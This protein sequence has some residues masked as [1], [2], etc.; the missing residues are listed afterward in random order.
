[1]SS[2]S[3]AV[4]RLCLQA[5]RSLCLGG[6]GGAQW[7]RASVSVLTR[8]P[9]KFAAAAP[10]AAAATNVRGFAAAGAAAAAALDGSGTRA[11]GAL[12]GAATHRGGAT[13]TA[14]GRG[15]QQ[16]YTS[17]GS[18]S[19]GAALRWGR[20]GAGAGAGSQRS[21]TTSSPRLAKKKVKTPKHLQ[22]ANPK[23]KREPNLKLLTGSMKLHPEPRGI[24]P[25]PFAGET[26]RL[27]QAGGLLRT[28]S[29][30]LAT[31]YSYSTNVQSTNRP[32]CV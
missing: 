32:A 26:G 14:T 11:A 23:K 1:M 3:R 18:G 28:S 20:A 22:V 5:G 31:R 16:W 17:G 8:M 9:Q 10:A 30:A 29:Q 15:G 13:A 6:H 24:Q 25:P 19:A 12:A 27:T 21:F 4:A 7:P 2:A